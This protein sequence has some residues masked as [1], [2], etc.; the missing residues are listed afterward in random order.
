M[1]KRHGEA[2]KTQKRNWNALYAVRECPEFHG[3]GVYTICEIFHLAG[4]FPLPYFFDLLI[5]MILVFGLHKGLSPT[6]SEEQLFDTPSRIVRLC[7]AYY[8][9][10]H[11]AHTKI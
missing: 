9:F 5:F 10:A 11:T 6:L 8:Q 2:L 1:V 3:V 4:A 7:A